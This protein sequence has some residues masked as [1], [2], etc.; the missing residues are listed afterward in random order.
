MHP[1]NG[2]NHNC[3]CVGWFVI[4]QQATKQAWLI[5][6]WSV[7]HTSFCLG[8]KPGPYHSL[9]WLIYT[10]WG[11]L[12]CVSLSWLRS[13]ST[14]RTGRSRSKLN[15]W[16]VF[17][18]SSLLNMHH[19]SHLQERKEEC[20]V[21]QADMTIK[22]QIPYNCICKTG[23]EKAISIGRPVS[24]TWA[25]VLEW[26]QPT[27]ASNEELWHSSELHKQLRGMTQTNETTESC[28]HC[29]FELWLL[30]Y[31]TVTQCQVAYC[32]LYLFR[33][34]WTNLLRESEGKVST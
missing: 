16:T 4:T 9:P 13:R 28:F 21:K 12:W 7:S 33:S 31:S 3:S 5:C 27:S 11:A 30:I 25:C 18:W 14:M 24:L 19:S 22:L 29:N 20:K 2:I 6:V 10:A 15:T 26:H 32:Y 1:I 23:S 8:C 34:T 17:L